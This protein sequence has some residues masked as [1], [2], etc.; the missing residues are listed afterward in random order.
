M[1]RYATR[2]A[3]VCM[4]LF[5]F[6][7]TQALCPQVAEAF[8][9]LED[10]TNWDTDRPIEFTVNLAYVPASFDR[11][12]YLQ[13]VREA[14]EQWRQVEMAELPFRIGPV[15]T[16]PSQTDPR[17]DGVNQIFW[18]PGFIPRD[19]FAGKAFPFESECDILLAPRPP[20]GLIDIKGIVIHELGHCMGLAHST[21]PGIMTK[22]TSLPSLGYDDRVAVS[23][24][25]PNRRRPLSETTATIEGR[26]VDRHRRP[27]IGAVLR[28]LDGRTSQVV[29]SGFSGLVDAQQRRDDAG[30]FELPG[31]PPGQ[32]RLE[33][34][35]MDAF[36]AADP[37]G[38]GAPGTPSHA[39]EPV[40]VELP[41]VSAGRSQSV[42]LLT[43]E[44]R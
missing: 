17:E 32:H 29:V 16:D 35:P 27:V 34:T 24:R 30:G 1:R 10:A 31:I 40:R 5:T 28:V 37:D 36:A 21:A 44:S 7:M 19:L 12:E 8:G 20:F 42:G 38:Y 13:T 4:T 43:V 6:H 23:L 33:I 25:Y 14:L 2:M 18:K 22:F 11:E 26:V 3:M 9:F 15:I 39:F 41:A